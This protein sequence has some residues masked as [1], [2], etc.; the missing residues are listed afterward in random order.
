MGDKSVIFISCGIFREELNY[1]VREK[2]LGWNIL[3]LDAAL[4]VNFDRLKEKLVQALEAAKERGME[5]RVIYG[6]C[7][8]EIEKI[9]GDYGARRIDAGNCLEAMAG[10]Q[11]VSR[12]NSEATTFFLSAG[13]VNHWEE[14]FT[15]GK[16]DFEFDFKSMFD[17]YKR[18]VLFDTGIIPIDVEKLRTFSDFTGLPIE[19]R[20]IT[21][22]YF[23]R[24]VNAIGNCSP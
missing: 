2:G 16:E 6:L 22:D 19:T 21:L 13:W 18:I 10:P 3:F 8:P 12:L 11:E 15:L 24:L 9:L 4:H 1:L 20:M 17:R 23:L 14:M 7:H 5:I